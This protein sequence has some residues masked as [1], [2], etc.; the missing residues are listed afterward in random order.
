MGLSS[1]IKSTK[2]NASSL[3]YRFDLICHLVKR[4]FTLLYKRSVLGV[5]WSLLLPL[6][7]LLVLIFIF[8]KIVPL[9]IK[10]YPAFVFT[11]LLPWTWFSNCLFSSAIL[12]LMN[13]DLLRRPNFEP[14]L[15]IVVNTLSNLLLF[16]IALPIL[17]IFLRYYERDVTL[18][19]CYIPVLIIVQGILIVGLGLIIATLNVFYSDIQHLLNV[20]LQILFY[21]T[22][23]FYGAELVGKDFSFI[24]T[25]N[26]MAGLIRNYREIIFEGNPLDWSSLLIAAII[27]IAICLL[28]FIIY[29]RNL[30]HVMD[31]I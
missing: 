18:T 31:E 2:V 6:A 17:F 26:P 30:H 21:L 9:K 20:A 23:V 11:G 15:L 1:T 4:D 29:R 19:I 16:L 13:R 24:Y 22:P 27:S 7:Q 14:S 3:N 10:D 25:F 28:G 5:L 8:Q 12:F